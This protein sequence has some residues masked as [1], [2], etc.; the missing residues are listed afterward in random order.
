MAELSDESRT[1]DCSNQSSLNAVIM[2]T[3][4]TSRL[5]AL[6]FPVVSILCIYSSSTL[7]DADPTVQP[8]HQSEQQ[9]EVNK[10]LFWNSQLQDISVDRKARLMGT[11]RGM[12]DFATSVTRQHISELGRR[13]LS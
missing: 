5:S 10:L 6:P 1:M 11:I 8:E 7:P 3:T 12:A 9:Q 4:N 13:E 2:T